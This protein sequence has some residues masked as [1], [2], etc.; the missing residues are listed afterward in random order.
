MTHPR[1]RPRQGGYTIIEV[2]VA[3]TVLSIGSSVLWYTLRS[4]AR[5]E[6][7]NRLHHEANLLARSELETLRVIPRA[8]I[9]DTAYLYPVSEAD[10]LLLVREVFDSA[11]VMAV[12]PE[13]PLDETLSPEELQKPLEVRVRVFASSGPDGDAIPDPYP[14]WEAPWKDGEEGAPRTLATLLLKLPEYRWH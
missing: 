3:L 11:D 10:T 1:S 7:Q 14:G 8:D 6:R 13:V 12:L 9:R 5:L 4:S 2:V